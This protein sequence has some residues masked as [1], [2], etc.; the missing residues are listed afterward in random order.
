MSSQY[1]VIDLELWLEEG[2]VWDVSGVGG[3]RGCVHFDVPFFVESTW[4]FVFEVSHFRVRI[5]VSESY[6][7]RTDILDAKRV[8]VLSVWTL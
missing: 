2:R 5:Q 6:G 1:I 4:G 3:R 8:I 7:T